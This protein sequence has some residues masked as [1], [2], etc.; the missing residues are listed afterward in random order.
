MSV[1]HMRV[2]V[3]VKVLLQIYLVATHTQEGSSH[4]DDGHING[5]GEDEGLRDGGNQQDTDSISGVAPTHV[6]PVGHTHTEIDQNFF[7]VHKH[8]YE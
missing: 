5:E 1:C 3:C 8:F 6:L 2:C 4:E 7:N